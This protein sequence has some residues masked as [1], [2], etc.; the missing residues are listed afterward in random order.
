MWGLY[1]F[2]MIID[3]FLRKISYLCIVFPKGAQDILLNSLTNHHQK[4]RAN[5]HYWDCPITGAAFPYLRVVCGE[6]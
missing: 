4:K 5:S 1:H 3:S 6:P 2:F